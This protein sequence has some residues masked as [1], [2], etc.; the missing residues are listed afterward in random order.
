MQPVSMPEHHLSEEIILDYAAGAAS[1]LTNLAVATHLVY[2]PHCRAELQRAEALGGLLLADAGAA[3][4]DAG[5]LDRVLSTLDRPPPAAAAPP[6]GDSDGLP[7]PL[8]RMV[9]EPLARLRWR[10]VYPGMWE[11]RL[12]VGRTGIARLLW[13]KPGAAMPQHSHRGGELTVVLR[14]S[15]RDELGRFRAGDVAV[16]DEQVDHR[17]VAD[18]DQDCICLAV[19]EGPLRLTG[20]FGR[21]VEFFR[22]H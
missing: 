1:A 20:P 5:M 4:V 22:P 9:V 14:G 13:I 3:G 7:A 10:L 6:S 19:N 16:T 8:R 15:Y 2:C 21:M 12:P 18:R 11:H 17:P